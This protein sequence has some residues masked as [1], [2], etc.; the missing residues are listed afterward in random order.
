MPRESKNHN[1]S[2]GAGSVVELSKRPK[3][4][5]RWAMANLIRAHT[6]VTMYVSSVEYRRSGRTHRHP[7]RPWALLATDAWR[8][9]AGVAE[10]RDELLAPD[11]LQMRD[12][13]LV[14]VVLSGLFSRPQRRER[15]MGTYALDGRKRYPDG[16]QRRNDLVD[17]ES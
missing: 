13:R 3:G 2:T 16:V 17:E 8:C 15:H 11:L 5:R 12:V 14:V 9:G 1:T 4:T 6:P 7:V 10:G